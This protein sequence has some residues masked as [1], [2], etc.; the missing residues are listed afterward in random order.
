MAVVPWCL[1]WYAGADAAVCWINRAFFISGW[2]GIKSRA[3]GM[4]A[5][6]SMGA[7]AALCTAYMLL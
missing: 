2:K 1:R 6:V 4:D 3:P 5:L 7:G